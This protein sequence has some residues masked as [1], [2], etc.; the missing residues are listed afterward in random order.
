[1]RPD[2]NRYGEA[3]GLLKRVRA[4]MPKALDRRSNLKLVREYADAAAE[5]DALDDVIADSNALLN[6]SSTWPSA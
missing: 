6:R 4:L 2:L 5:L 3:T 1:M